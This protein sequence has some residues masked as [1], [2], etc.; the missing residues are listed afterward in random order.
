MPADQAEAD[1][2][3]R[4]FSASTRHWRRTTSRVATV[5]TSAPTV[6]HSLV[7][8]QRARDQRRPSRAAIGRQRRESPTRRSGAS[9]R[10][11]WAE[12][13]RRRPWER[14]ACSPKSAQPPAQRRGGCPAA[15]GR[16]RDAH[17]SICVGHHPSRVQS[18]VR[19]CRSRGG[20]GIGQAHGGTPRRHVSR[21]RFKGRRTTS[22]LDLRG[23]AI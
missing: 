10:R 15:H 20:R 11:T 23:I 6:S 5:S 21:R 9:A 2:R 12:R 1:L 18:G 14:R 22:A 8:D 3:P 4:L 17:P 13:R 19:T 16:R 7:A